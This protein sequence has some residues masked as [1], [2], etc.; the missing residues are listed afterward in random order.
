MGIGRRDRL[1]ASRARCRVH[2]RLRPEHR[3]LSRLAE[4]ALQPVGCQAC[5][6][7]RHGQQPG[8]AHARLLGDGSRPTVSSR[9]SRARRT[10]S[11]AADS[12][13]HAST[14]QWREAGQWVGS[15]RSDAGQSR[16]PRRLLQRRRDDPGDD[17]LA[18]CRGGYR[19]RSRRRR[20]ERSG[21]AVCAREAGA[22]GCPRPAPRE[23][24]P[25]RRVDDGPG[26]DERAVRHAVF[27]R[28]RPLAGRD[29]TSCGRTGCEPG[30]VLRLG[31]HEDVWPRDGIPAERARAVSLARHVHALHA[32]VLAVPARCA[33]RERRLADDRRI[34]GLGS[35]DAHGGA[36]TNGSARPAARL[37]VPAW[38]RR[39]LPATRATSTSRSTRSCASG[40][41]S[42]SPPARETAACRR[43]PEY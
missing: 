3:R 15:R 16:D 12:D 21:D 20:F 1:R 19:V 7:L 36:R 4:P 39:T 28:R 22:R 13:L 10:S 25:L 11:F 41:P 2:P 40:T 43:L 24:R 34:R 9:S 17:R 42:S 23:R 38:L 30:R 33:H 37:S 8:A 32:C 14:G 31:R 6:R 18:S 35:V 29:G 26:S 27:F 5:L